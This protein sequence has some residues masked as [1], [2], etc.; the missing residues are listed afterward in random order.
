MAKRFACPFA[1]P[2]RAHRLGQ[3]FGCHLALGD[4]KRPFLG[5]DRRKFWCVGTGLGL[6]LLRGMEKP[7]GKT[8]E[9][10]T[11]TSSNNERLCTRF[12]NLS[13]GERLG[14]LLCYQGNRRRSQSS[15]F[16]GACRAATSPLHCRRKEKPRR[17]IHR[18]DFGPLHPERLRSFSLGLPSSVRSGFGLHE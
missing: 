3:V 17:K 7:S 15:D 1:C 9:I 16:E 4:R 2:R 12:A 6:T 10:F 14:K 5:D 18:T 11:R 13:G 8:D